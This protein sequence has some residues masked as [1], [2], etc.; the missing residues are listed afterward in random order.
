MSTMRVASRPWNE[1]EGAR[2]MARDET[3]RLIP[4]RAGLV[5]HVRRGCLLATQEGD[6]QDHVLETGDELRLTGPGM[7]VA[8]A[9]S[10]A[11]L[12]VV[13]DAAAPVRSVSPSKS[14]SVKRAATTRA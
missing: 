2:E 9:L 8:W 14:A 7:V 1:R 5:L 10:P 13:H 12:V 11:N 6:L 3:I 4:G